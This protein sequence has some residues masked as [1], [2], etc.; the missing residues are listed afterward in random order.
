MWF[1]IFQF[2]EKSIHFEENTL[3]GLLKTECTKKANY[4]KVPCARRKYKTLE[5]MIQMSTAQSERFKTNLISG[6][7]YSYSHSQPENF[8]KS[9]SKNHTT[10]K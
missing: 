10:S 9:S 4:F 2:A 7:L 6:T 8:K 3:L 1:K 5:I